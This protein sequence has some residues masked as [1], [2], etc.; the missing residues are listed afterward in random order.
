M[1]NTCAIVVKGFLNLDTCAK[2]I[3]SLFQ[4]FEKASNMSEQEKLLLSLVELLKKSTL[5]DSQF[6]EIEHQVSHL[7]FALS[8]RRETFPLE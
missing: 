7:S 6:N 5:H 3:L 1:K 8:Q 2:Q 4:M